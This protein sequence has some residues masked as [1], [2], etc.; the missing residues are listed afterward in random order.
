MDN[1]FLKDFLRG[2]VVAGISK[3]V[4]APIE[5]VKLLLQVQDASSQIKPEDKYKGIVDCFARVTKEQGF[6]SLWRGNTANV[7]R[8]FPTQAFNFAFKDT[9]KILFNTKG[10]D[11]NKEKLKFLGLNIASGGF[12]G[13]TTGFI[14]YP[15]DMA[16]TRLAADVGTGANRQ[17]KGLIDCTR[18][19]AKS[20]GVKGLYRGFTISAVGYF[21]YRGLYFGFYDTAIAIA[22]KDL[23]LFYKWVIAQTVVTLSTFCSYPIDT[24][25]RRLM[26]QAGR[27]GADIM[28]TGTIDCTKKVIAKE[29]FRALF[30]G[31]WSN[32][33]RGVGAALVLV[34]YDEVKKYI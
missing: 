27:K 12:A 13:A 32:T 14:V 23:N 25:R 24:V 11:K 28:Y 7:I 19:I 9:Y 17:Y 22:G 26:M 4:V 8:Y 30:K 29:G 2:G 3:T 1:E 20:D 21:I 18:S 15:I 6:A 33:L 16:R 10:V 31:A 5:R 34:G